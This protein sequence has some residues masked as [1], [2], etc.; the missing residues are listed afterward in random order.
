MT[1]SQKESR[2]FWLCGQGGIGKSV[3]AAELLRR[4][5]TQASQVKGQSPTCEEPAIENVI[6]AHHFCTHH[7]AKQS[8]PVAL[9]GSL[10]C[11]MCRN[12]NGYKDALDKSVESV[13]G[14][15]AQ[16]KVDDIFEKL[17]AEPLRE[18]EQP[19]NNVTI[20]ID[21]LDELPKTT[22]E[23]T[24]RILS[25]NFVRLPQWLK[26]TVTSREEPAVRKAFKGFQPTELRADEARNR[27]D[28]S[29]YLTHIAREHRLGAMNIPDLELMVKQRFG[30]SLDLA[31]LEEPM[32]ASRYIYDDAMGEV[33]KDVEGIQAVEEV[34][35]LKPHPPPVQEKRE[36]DGEGL[37]T[38][39]LNQLFSDAEI[40][41]EVLKKV[42]A[43]DWELFRP[44]NL[45]RPKAS[46]KRPWVDDAVDPG[47][48]GR[49]R[50]E[51]KVKNDYG[52]DP[53]H[54]K[55]H[56]RLTFVCKSASRMYAVTIVLVQG[57]SRWV[58]A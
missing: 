56:A 23:T 29:V 48:K 41:R 15:L 32:R 13:Q 37:G 39:Y 34:P 1:E 6:I 25:Q 11:M 3:F 35:V 57:G 17:F 42:V 4:R 27:Q 31:A 38:T 18:V 45:H 21:A 55:D 12:L 26:W 28:M 40:A 33:R 24:L 14:A 52:G 43:D 10:A 20:L 2:L 8:E 44:P 16:G 51:Q 50:A 30:I 47:L 53:R 36:M 54:L 19:K 7:N 49:E 22:Q 5:S 9:M 46:S 58:W